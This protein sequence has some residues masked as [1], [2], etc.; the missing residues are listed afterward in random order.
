MVDRLLR[1]ILVVVGVSISLL[2]ASARDALALTTSIAIGG[3]G[4]FLWST[5]SLSASDLLLLVSGA[6]SISLGD[7]VH[8]RIIV[9]HALSIILVSLSLLLLFSGQVLSLGVFPDS[10]YTTEEAFS[11]KQVWHWHPSRSE[12]RDAQPPLIV[13]HRQ[14]ARA[15]ALTAVASPPTSYFTPPSRRAPSLPTCP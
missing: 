9:R 12:K 2:A 6:L 11:A 3:S 14:C 8:V 10:V 13:R 1:V 5:T 4:P 7:T 15:F